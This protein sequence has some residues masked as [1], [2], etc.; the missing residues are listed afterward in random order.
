MKI[1]TVFCLA[2]RYE[3]LGNVL[4]ESMVTGAPVV[5]TDC[6]SGPAEIVDNGKYGLLVPPEDPDAIAD[7]LIRVLSDSEL[8][9]TLSKLS[10]KRARD[11]DFET[12]LKQW[13]NTILAL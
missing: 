4:L 1:A 13:E 5:V 10:L 12:S 2:S 11:F 3:G 9:D 8:R 7:A 6:P